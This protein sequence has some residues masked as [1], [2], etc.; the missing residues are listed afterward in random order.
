MGLPPY[1]IREIYNTLSAWHT[2]AELWVGAR[3]QG[4]LVAI[5]RDLTFSLRTWSECLM[6][7]IAIPFVLRQII[8]IIIIIT[9]T[10][11]LQPSTAI[12]N[13]HLASQFYSNLSQMSS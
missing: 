1:T 3:L 11:D 4:V 7:L 6:T 2:H 12:L 5:K 13:N 9:S 10:G 8:I